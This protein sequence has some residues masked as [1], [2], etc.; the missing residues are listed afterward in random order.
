MQSSQGSRL[1]R[2]A[3]RPCDDSAAPARTVSPN[4]SGA[5]RTSCLR[6][7]SPSR[8]DRWSSG[9]SRT[10]EAFAAASG[11]R[12]SPAPSAANTR[13][14]RSPRRP[15]A[16]PPN[17]AT[18]Y[19]STGATTASATRRNWPRRTPPSPTSIRCPAR[20]TQRRRRPLPCT[21][22]LPLHR[23]HTR[24]PLQVS[25]RWV[26]HV[27]RVPEPPQLR[28]RP[29]PLHVVQVSMYSSTF[30]SCRGAVT[31]HTQCD[32]RYFRLDRGV[33]LS[34]HR[35]PEPPQ[36]LQLPLPEQVLHF[37]V[38]QLPFFPLPLHTRHIPL[39]LHAA[40]SFFAMADPS[41]ERAR[42]PSHPCSKGSATPLRNVRGVVSL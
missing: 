42:C 13:W 26:I 17:W 21:C 9:A 39:P 32:M 7:T 10:N 35:L 20:E 25:H 12:R 23:L 14:S 8:S 34:G 31:G 22:P 37:V 30:R 6:W 15:A 29:S 11:G 27:P 18:T 41:A 40:H 1:R 33:R 3:D 4:S 38:T 36:G 24:L 28:Q 16:G 5:L 2:R 19:P